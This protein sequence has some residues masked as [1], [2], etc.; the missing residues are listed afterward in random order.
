MR[1][2]KAGCLLADTHETKADLVAG[3]DIQCL[4]AGF[5]RVFSFH[6]DYVNHVLVTCN[7]VFMQMVSSDLNLDLLPHTCSPACGCADEW[8]GSPVTIADE[9]VPAS[10]Y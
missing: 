2:V 4:I 10:V 9:P 6:G 3:C 7:L 1:V 5:A 8:L